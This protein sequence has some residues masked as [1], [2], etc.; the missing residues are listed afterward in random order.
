[1]GVHR[2]ELG[3]LARA[4]HSLIDRQRGQRLMRRQRP[5][6]HL[7]TACRAR[8]PVTQI[9]DDRPAHVDRERHPVIAAALADDE[10]LARAPVD[11]IQRQADDLAAAQ[12]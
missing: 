3:T 11:V 12:P 4:V 2:T 1:M 9:R 8:P 10:Q 7:T 6:E 5:H